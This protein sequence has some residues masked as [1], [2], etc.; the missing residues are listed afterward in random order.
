LQGVV[1]NFFAADKPVAAICHGV[2]LAARS[3]RA[4]GKSVLHGHTTTA[5]LESMELLAWRLT[6]RRL[7]DY[8]LTYPDITVQRE[9][10]EALA[11]PEDFVEG[12]RPFLRDH[13]RKLGRGFVVRDGNY[14]SARYPGDVHRF[15]TTF[16][17]MLDEGS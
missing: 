17:N 2:V 12:P 13:E 7:G 16:A 9:V 5:L 10:T 6:R 1:A 11:R 15:A 8:Y 4:D 3:R 14:L